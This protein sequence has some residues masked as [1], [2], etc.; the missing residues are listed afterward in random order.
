MCVIGHFYGSLLIFFIDFFPNFAE[1]ILLPVFF[2]DPR[3]RGSMKCP[4]EGEKPC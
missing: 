2:F 3:I 1:N 4:F